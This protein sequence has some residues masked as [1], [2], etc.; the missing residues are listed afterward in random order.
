MNDDDRRLAESLHRRANA[1]SPQQ[2]ELAD[3]VHRARGIRRRRRT[4]VSVAAVA[5]V[6][7][8]AVPTS[9]TLGGPQAG[10]APGPAGSTTSSHAPSSTPTTTP[11]T[12]PATTPPTTPPTAPSSTAQSAPTSTLRLADIKTGG[13]IRIGWLQGR[14]WHNG[15][16]DSWRLPTGDYSAVTPYRGG[17]L[18]TRP[19]A[20]GG[21]LSGAV[22][23]VTWLDNNL[24][25]QW[26]TCGNQRLAISPDLMR[27]AYST[28]SACSSS[29][30]GTLHVGIG[31]GMANGEQTEPVP[32]G[33]LA[34]PVGF[35][36]QVLVYNAAA[37]ADGTP[38][39]VWYVD[40]AGSSAPRRI[41]GLANAS[42]VDT[43]GQLVAGQSAADP[44]AGVLVD[45]VTGRPVWSQPDWLLGSF[46]GDGK[47][48]YAAHSAGAEPD[49]YAILDASTG[50]VVTSVDLS[51]RGI[52][53]DD[54]AWNADGTL[55]LHVTQGDHQ[56]ILDLTPAGD[57]TR[58][59]K[60][61]PYD[62]AHRIVFATQP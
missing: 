45:P 27:V 60:V 46:S 58:A 7:A 55:L 59:T 23:D 38:A 21:A 6:A 5:A 34:E 19:H 10:I 20:S 32:G 42:A 17:F 61:M 31:S 14:T 22:A 39:G 62:A 41:K 24:K 8:I 12:T 36:D 50:A 26:T 28:L 40:L 4:A 57:L 16:S 2:A 44:Q 1:F 52:T 11:T 29:A 37:I 25:P 53:V 47:Y 43:T 51:S 30:H 35:A 13:L 33:Q 9:L 49:R 15:T 56:A 3:V 48:L 18:V 54:V